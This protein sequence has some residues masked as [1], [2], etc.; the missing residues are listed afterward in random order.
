[1]QLSVGQNSQDLYFSMETAGS[2]FE[3]LIFIT[4][5][6]FSCYVSIS[7]EKKHLS[8]RS[9][10][11]FSQQSMALRPLSGLSPCILH[12]ETSGI[13]EKAQEN[14]IFRR[15]RSHSEHN[16]HK[17]IPEAI[18]EVLKYILKTWVH[19]HLLLVSARTVSCS[20]CILLVKDACKIQK[21]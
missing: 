7:C 15:V 16:S 1:M 11:P 19:W 21:C 18:F 17:S 14:G 12:T 20:C 8:V 6:T 4:H 3:W 5:F 9:S 13:L 2:E 10:V